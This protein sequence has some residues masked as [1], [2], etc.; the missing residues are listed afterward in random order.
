LLFGIALRMRL[1][2]C[3]SM[4][5]QSNELDTRQLLSG[6]QLIVHVGTSLSQSFFLLSPFHLVSVWVSWLVILW[7]RLFKPRWR[8][9]RRGYKS[10]RG[11][12]Y[13][14]LNA[15][16]WRRF[17]WPTDTQK[18]SFPSIHG[19]AWDRERVAGW[20]GGKERR[21]ALS[22]KKAKP[23]LPYLSLLHKCYLIIGHSFW[24]AA[25]FTRFCCLVPK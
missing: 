9:C 21:N 18:A 24:S 2:W 5:S 4:P 25:I 1:R 17:H 13:R 12:Q 11:T 7:G 6:H 3:R 22:V 15:C 23:L 8:L 19:S 14:I 16:Q 10:D 20:A